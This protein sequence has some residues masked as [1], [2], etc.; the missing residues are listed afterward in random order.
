VYKFLRTVLITQAFHPRRSALA[1]FDTKE[2]SFVS[3]VVKA[4]LAMIGPCLLGARGQLRLACRV[5]RRSQ[6][7]PTGVLLRPFRQRQRAVG[8]I[9][10]G[11]RE[12]VIHDLFV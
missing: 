1:T 6:A 4:N 5:P 11:D 9:L 2:G 8:R 12:T 3:P 10:K 7:V